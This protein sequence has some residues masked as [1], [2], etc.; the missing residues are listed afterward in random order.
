[1]AWCSRAGATSAAGRRA[2]SAVSM[3]ACHD[4]SNAGKASC[5]SSADTAGVAASRF[6][7]AGSSLALLNAIDFGAPCGAADRGQRY[8]DSARRTLL[9]GHGGIGRHRSGGARPAQRYG[10]CLERMAEGV[11]DGRAFEAAVRHAVVARRVT[12]DPIRLPVGLLHELAEGVSMA[13]IGQ[14]V[15]GALPAEDIEG[16][17]APRSALVRLIAGEEVQ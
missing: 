16:R 15:T 11:I 3:R 5:S 17:G 10:Q 6:T 4:F 2:A 8:R 1:M 14:Q 7:A 13:F 9:V 12:P